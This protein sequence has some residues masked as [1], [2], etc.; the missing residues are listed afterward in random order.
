MKTYTNPTCPT[1]A[2]YPYTPLLSI[3]FLAFITLGLLTKKIEPSIE[4]TISFVAIGIVLMAVYDIS[5]HKVHHH[6]ET[7]LNF[8]KPQHNYNLRRILTKIWGQYVTFGLIYTFYNFFAEYK[9][10]FYQPFFDMIHLIWPYLF[11]VTPFYITYIDQNMKKPHDA[12]YHVGQLCCLNLHILHHNKNKLKQYALGWIVKAFFLPLMLLWTHKNTEYFYTFSETIRDF[13]FV[14]IALFS[15]IFLFSIDVYF[16]AIGYLST[17]RIINAHIRSS[18]YLI[19]GWMVTLV[20]YPPFDIIMPLYIMKKDENLWINWL[21][22]TPILY[23]WGTL[24]IACVFLYTWATITFCYR[25]SNL[26]YRGIITNGPYMYFKHPAYLFKNIMWW[27]GAMPFLSHH[28]LRDAVL[29]TGGLTLISYIYYLRAKTEEKHLL[30]Y[31]T[32][33]KYCYWIEVEGF[34]AK[35]RKILE[36]TVQTPKWRILR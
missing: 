13:N 10:D 3:L 22:G 33:R 25:F 5:V 23:L 36:K 11:I 20:C 18:Q 17:L 16:A 14:K 26:T 34:F 8:N 12:L 9:L 32:Y 31:K 30:Q 2:S 4:L 6:K 28:G 27:L 15:T 35:I 21:Q 1:S 19:S 7:G 24:I 29:S